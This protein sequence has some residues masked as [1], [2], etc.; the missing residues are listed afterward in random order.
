MAEGFVV[1]G[2]VGVGER[3]TE[4]G[5]FIMSFGEG[6]YRDNFLQ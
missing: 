4:W 2:W 6:V 3:E 1:V 5:D